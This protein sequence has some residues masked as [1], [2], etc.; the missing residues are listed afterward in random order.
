MKIVLIA[1]A[2]ISCVMAVACA[3]MV[4]DDGFVVKMEHM[5]TGSLHS[6]GRMVNPKAIVTNEFEHPVIR[7]ARLHELQHSE[8]SSAILDYVEDNI[9]KID[10]TDCLS[11]ALGLLSYLEETNSLSRL[12]T[13]FK[14]NQ[15]RKLTLPIVN[16]ILRRSNR[17]F[18]KY[19]DAVNN[20]SD[21]FLRMCFYDGIANMMDA[22]S[23]VS[24]CSLPSR[25]TEEMM[26]VL[27]YAS[28]IEQDAQNKLFIEKAISDF[29]K[30][31]ECG[32][33]GKSISHD[34]K[35]DS[36]RKREI[37]FAVALLVFI[38][39]VLVVCGKIKV[40]EKH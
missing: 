16:A 2:F 33:V 4:V 5:Y 34:K 7:Y 26:S 25:R 9:G 6:Y 19:V 15:N 35:S 28:I 39:F 20:E 22:Y 12:E 23:K 31:H 38:A 11:K 32:Y 21:A 30:K 27:E 37:V 29:C 8:I 3:D 10:K 17:D 40:L 13:L 18:R 1:V 14:E 24:D 36:N